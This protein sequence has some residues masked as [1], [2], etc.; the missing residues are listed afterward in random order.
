VISKVNW[1]DGLSEQAFLDEYWQQKPLLIKQ[2]LPGFETPISPDELA[3]LAIEEDTTPRLI[4]QNAAGE[5]TVENGPFDAERFATL[6]YNDWSLLVTDVEKHLPDISEYLTPFQFLPSWRIDDLMIS[7]APDGASVGA[8][9]D[10]YDVFL[11]QAS[12]TRRWLIDDSINPDVTL[13]KGATLKLLANFNA[14]H[15]FDL[16][17]GDILYLPPGVPHHGVA[18]GDDCTTWSVGFRAPA[19]ADI[20]NEFSELLAS[21]LPAKRYTDP[22]LNIATPGE[23]SDESIAQFG[24]LWREATQLSEEQL[25]SLVG[26]LVST[27]SIDAERESITGSRVLELDWIKH[28]FSRFAFSTT[29]ETTHLFVDSEIYE[30]SNEFAKQLCAGKVVNGQSFNQQDQNVLTKLLANG[31][32]Q[33]VNE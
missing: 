30:C 4:L 18:I 16:T 26:R 2:G 20:V 14:S 22:K 12:G 25:A 9:V 15:T 27:P 24:Q 17:P 8:H 7:Y 32:M 1:P 31:A 11:V 6:Q 23:I 33:A 19:L 13:V 29:N 28:P 5:F 10:E 3:G 21:E